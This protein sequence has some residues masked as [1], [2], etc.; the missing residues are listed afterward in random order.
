[1][2]NNTFVENTTTRLT[3]EF[4]DLTGITCMKIK[5]QVDR[6]EFPNVH[7]NIFLT[8]GMQTLPLLLNL[9]SL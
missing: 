3:W 2:K 4:S 6:Y 8:G 1:M 5:R 7:G 9:K